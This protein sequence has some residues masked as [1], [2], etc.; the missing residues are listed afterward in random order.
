MTV[1]W[2]E[3][4]IIISNPICPWSPV[5]IDKAELR[6]LRQ[7]PRPSWKIPNVLIA[8]HNKVPLRNEFARYNEKSSVLHLHVAASCLMRVARGTRSKYTGNFHVKNGIYL[9]KWKLK[10]SILKEL[11]MAKFRHILNHPTAPYLSEG[12]YRDIRREW[13]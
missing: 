12:K 6:L 11:R 7:S 10:T 9:S 8:Y 3:V 1:V 13:L 4:K 2:V 5:T